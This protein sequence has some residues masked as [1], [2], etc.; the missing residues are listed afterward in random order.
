MGWRDVQ[1]KI[2]SGELSYAPSGMDTFFAS[3]SSSFRK[4]YTDALDAQA[5]ALEKTKELEL[6]N[7]RQMKAALR[8]SKEILGSDDKAAVAYAY[9]VIKDY[10]GNVGQATERLES[11]SD[12]E[13]LE[14]VPSGSFGALN[15]DLNSET[16]D[17]FTMH[18]SGS[19]GYNALLGQAQN[20]E[21]FSDVKVTEMTMDEVLDFVSPGGAYSEYSLTATVPGQEANEKGIPSTPVGKF[22]FVGKT[23]RD[24]RDRGGFEELGITGTTLYD[25]DTQNKLF[26]WYVKDTMKASGGD[27]VAY[28]EK[29]RNRFEGFRKKDKNGEFVVT[30]KQLDD[31]HAK[32]KDGQFTT[33]KVSNVEAPN[34]FDVGKR[35][36]EITG[37]DEEALIQIEQL[38]AEILAEGYD[39]TDDQNLLITN[40]EEEI[41]KKIKENGFFKFDTFLEENRLTDKGD[42]TAAIAVIEQMSISQF[43]NGDTEKANYTEYLR[44]MYNDF[45]EQ[46]QKENKQKSD[47]DRDPFV[48]YPKNEDGA[49]SLGGRLVILRDGKYYEQTNPN[50]EVDVTNGKLTS[51]DYDAST[52][53]KIYNDNI[54]KMG[55]IITDGESATDILLRYRKLAYENP[56]AFNVIVNAANS[57]INTA[58]VMAS[59]FNTLINEGASYQEVLGR[60]ELTENFR[61]LSD[62][63][64]Q[65]FSLQ[66]QAAYSLARLNGSSGQGLSD[67]ELAQNLEAVGFSAP[68]ARIALSLI[69]QSLLTV[70]GRTNTRRK[71]ILNALIGDEDYIDAI[72]N[73]PISKPFNK[74]MESVVTA[75]GY[76]PK[77]L[78]QYNLA[79]EGSVEHVANAEDPNANIPILTRDAAG[80]EAWNNAPSGTKF[81]VE[82]EDGS[83]VIKTKP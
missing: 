55:E 22:Q 13:R 61:A 81:K 27:K 30:D 23:L 40:V 59:G 36:G 37:R 31:I 20:T 60:F 57:L 50:V 32:V 67:K 14:I 51:Q 3:A 80:T 83:F 56:A 42:V 48:F 5:D 25:E 71:G 62:P 41:K 70:E 77:L 73:K 69:N 10:E 43:K 21:Q 49:L 46:E 52:F 26:A 4:Y 6:E 18:E 66:L 63:A 19:G 58:D 7:D 68:N 9:N 65:M 76:D 29:M 74:Y 11:L 28:R 82:Q 34:R 24:I 33:G 53:I 72:R 8:L 78:E 64:K 16:L 1:R 15:S 35:L 54:I 12:A 75:E 79:K 47:Q 44:Q 39:L 2:N 38:K 17:L 45:D